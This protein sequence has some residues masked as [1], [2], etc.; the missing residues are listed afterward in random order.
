MYMYTHMYACT[1]M[2]IIIIDEICTPLEVKGDLARNVT[3]RSRTVCHLTA[4]DH[5]ML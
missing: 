5:M 3:T 2:Y 4:L 1:Y